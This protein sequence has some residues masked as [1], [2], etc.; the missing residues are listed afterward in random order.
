MAQ[1]EITKR[2]A[3][4]WDTL[5]ALY[6]KSGNRCAFSG[7]ARSLVSD[8]GDFV[9]QVC[10]IEAAEPGGE[11]FNPAQT[12]EERRHVSNLLLMCYDHHVETDNVDKFPVE[13]MQR[14]KEEHEQKFSDVIGRILA[15]VVDHTTLS[16]PVKPTSLQKLNDVLGW[17]LSKEE[18]GVVV[19]QLSTMV[20]ALSQV[21][22][23]ARELF[24]VVVNRA[25]KE[26][27][28]GAFSAPAAEIRH[29]VGLG[30]KE[31][32]SLFAILDRYGFTFDNGTGEFGGHQVGVCDVSGWPAWFDIRTFCR[33]QNLDL[34]QLI[35]SLDFSVLD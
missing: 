26:P 19:H 24:L 7:C 11:R 35:L 1:G 28:L 31:L 21:P 32:R 25:S 33:K 27:G 15:T 13:R 18:F 29:A 14:I 4:T 17:T 20:D 30:T 3:P 6:L 9:G 22:I 23:P 12:N 10:H 2:L 34:S 5:R 16:A 8:D